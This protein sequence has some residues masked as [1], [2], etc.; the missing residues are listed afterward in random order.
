MT[1]WRVFLGVVVVIVAL[2]FIVGEQLTGA[3]ADATINARLVTIRSPIAGA[4]SVPDR[5]LGSPV[6]PGEVVATVEDSRVDGVRLDDLK[7]QLGLADAEITRLAQERKKVSSMVQSLRQRVDL[8]RAAR[9]AELETRLAFARERLAILENREWPRAFDVRPPDASALA[10]D[11]TGGLPGQRELWISAARERVALLENE[12]ATARQGVFLGDGYNDAPNAGQRL[13][14]LKGELDKLAV[15]ADHADA[16]RT[17]LAQ[18]L[19]RELLRV[20]RAAGEELV[21]PVSGVYWEV[22]AGDKEEVQRG[23]PVA[24]I[25]DCDSTVVTLSVTQ[26]VYNTLSVGSPAVFRP[27]GAGRNFDATILRLGGS[28]AATFYRNL[29]V[30]PSERHLERYDVM[31]LVPQL[32]ADPELGCATGRTGRVFFERRPLDWLRSL[33]N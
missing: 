27:L 22:L 28:G 21:S 6:T 24:R 17:Q 26:S 3:S 19:D 10:G 8:Y 30:A 5:P 23:D 14:E 16:R 11:A 20:T 1:F 29:A 7:M 9:I 4:L 15:Q 13:V 31:V 33:W 18:R 12:F 2:W 25:L 32:N